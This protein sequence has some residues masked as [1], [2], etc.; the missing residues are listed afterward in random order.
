MA[1]LDIR[2]RE[3]LRQIFQTSRLHDFFLINFAVKIDDR[4]VGTNGARFE[5]LDALVAFHEW[6]INVR[7]LSPFLRKNLDPHIVVFAG[8]VIV[9]VHLTIQIDG[10]RARGLRNAGHLQ[11]F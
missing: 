2:Q 11:L 4:T 8:G 9:T 3:G 5:A 1:N 6:N 10:W 7:V